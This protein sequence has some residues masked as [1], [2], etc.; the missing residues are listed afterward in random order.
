[1]S[2]HDLQ[3]AFPEAADEIVYVRE[4]R[5]GELPDSIVPPPN[6]AKIYAIHDSNGAR[7]A[8]T[9]D[10]GLAFKLARKHDRKPMSV[11]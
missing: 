6:G 5:D 1:M 7:L 4:V 3:T 2:D 8:L 9:D 11:H 10:R